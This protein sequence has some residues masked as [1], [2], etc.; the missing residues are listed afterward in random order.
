LPAFASSDSRLSRFDAITYGLKLGVHLSART[1]LY[2]RGDYYHQMG[3]AHPADAIGQLRNQ[4]LFQG[5]N[6]SI[7]QAGLQWKFH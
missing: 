3:A 4:N 2:L 1:E 6:A 7:I 5:V